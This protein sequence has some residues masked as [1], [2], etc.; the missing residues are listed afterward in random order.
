MKQALV[1]LVMIM[2]IEN[3]QGQSQ[4][5]TAFWSG[6]SAKELITT[7][8]QGALERFADDSTVDAPLTAALSLSDAGVF[9]T[10]RQNVSVCLQEDRLD[11]MLMLTVP[12]TLIGHLTIDQYVSLAE[13]ATVTEMYLTE[14]ALIVR[15]SGGAWPGSQLSVFETAFLL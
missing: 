10:C 1:I 14:D 2:G 15:F 9:S 7:E 12:S 6:T 8:P 4:G 13:I 11:T 5:S 3:W